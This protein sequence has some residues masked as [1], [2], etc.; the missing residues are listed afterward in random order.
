MK[1]MI[2][3]DE[4][5]IDLN[6]ELGAGTSARVYKGI[7]QGQEVAVKVMSGDDFDEEF[8][9]ELRIISKLQ[10]PN[11]LRVLGCCID[12]D[13]RRCSIVADHYEFTLDIFFPPLVKKMKRGRRPPKGFWSPKLVQNLAKQIAQGMAFLHSQKMI[14]RDLKPA[15]CLLS[16]D[17]KRVVLADFGLS[18]F[19]ANRM[20]MTGQLGTP[21]YMAIEMFEQRLQASGDGMELSACDV[22]SFGVLLNA[23][24]AQSRPY[25]GQKMNAFELLQKVAPFALFPPSASFLFCLPPSPFYFVCTPLRN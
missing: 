9:H 19:L 10:H 21:A 14:H 18:K 17:L 24:W 20:T 3:P 15:N 2:R 6:N 13:E 4:L 8:K 7:F 1:H 23:M 25:E 16:A 11:I 22:F 5:E 12:S